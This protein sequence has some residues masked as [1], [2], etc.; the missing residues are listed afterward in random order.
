MRRRRNQKKSFIQ[1][2][3][4][5][6]FLSKR[7]KIQI[8]CLLITSFMAAG[9]EAISLASFYPFLSILTDVKIIKDIPII[10]NYF[11]YFKIEDENQLLF[12]V[13]FN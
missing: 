13:T 12:H 1:I 4:I 2:F 5:Y 10:N 9:A 3:K 11:L 8:F 7:R 6:K